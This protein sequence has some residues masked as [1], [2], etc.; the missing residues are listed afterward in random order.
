MAYSDRDLQVATQIAYYDLSPA[1]QNVHGKPTTLNELLSIDFSSNKQ[2]IRKSIDD[3]LTQA[4]AQKNAINIQRFTKQQELY[5]E[6]VSGNSPYS[7]WKIADIRD[8]NSQNGFYACTI[9]TNS[10]SAIVGFRGSEGADVPHQMEYD[11]VDSDIGLVNSKQTIEQTQATKYMQDIANDARFKK[12]S[13]LALTGHSLGGNLADHA[14]LT[15][16]DS[17]QKR[18]TQSVS[19]DGPNFSYEY[20]KAHQAE[21]Q[22]M[23]GKM[24]HF[25]WS[26]VGTLLVPLPGVNNV[27]VRTGDLVYGKY[28]M[29]SL[30]YKH[31]TGFLCFDGK[32]HLIGG[33]TDTFADSMGKITRA[34]DAAPDWVGNNLKSLLGNYMLAPDGEKKAIDIGALLAVGGSLLPNPTASYQ[35]IELAREYFAEP[36][37]FGVRL[38]AFL[39]QLANSKSDFG[40]LFNAEDRLASR[41][42]GAENTVR[43]FSWDS[44]CRFIDIVNEVEHENPLDIT[45]WDIWYRVENLF[46]GL[47]IESYSSDINDYYRKIIDI[48]DISVKQV[49]AIFDKVHG[50]DHKYAQKVNAGNESIQNINQQLKALSDSIVVAPE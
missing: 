32:G 47:N 49:Q 25:Q 18:I 19:F 1:F 46:G 9:E 39:Q 12:Y 3:N 40:K 37:Q 21:I 10:N 5:N 15:A 50:I 14:A 33:K 6:I 13:S 41:N 44:Y 8:T 30:L 4:K 24:T 45:K 35:A 43:D 34:I 26:V 36:T 29:N 17:I 2:S 28:D 7:N 23:R 38:T 11:W 42:F 20:I 31:D 16:P 27:V 48:N 22:K